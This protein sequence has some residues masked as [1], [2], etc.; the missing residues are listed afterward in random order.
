MGTLP[1]GTLVRANVWRELEAEPEGWAIDCEDTAPDRLTS[2][3][4]GVWSMGPGAKRWDDLRVDSMT[5]P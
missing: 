5:E 3:R 1:Y 4:V 2:G